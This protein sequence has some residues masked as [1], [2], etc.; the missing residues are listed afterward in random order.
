MQRNMRSVER[1]KKKFLRRM[2]QATFT[3]LSH[4][5][6]MLPVTRPTDKP[7]GD[8]KQNKL[9]ERFERKGERVRVNMKLRSIARSIA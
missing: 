6:T 9:D 1:A 7:R 5:K 8:S 2:G 3:G 4:H